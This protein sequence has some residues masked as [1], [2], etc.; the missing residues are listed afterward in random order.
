MINQNT[1]LILGAGSSHEAGFPLGEKLIKEIY[2]F[3]QEQTTGY[4]RHSD[5]HIAPHLLQNVYLLQLL[6]DQAGEK[7]QDGNTYSVDDIKAF[8]RDLWDSKVASIDDFLFHRKEY[9]LIGK[10]CILFVLSKYEDPNRFFPKKVSP[11]QW[12]YP[13]WGWYSYLWRQLQES[14]DGDFDI[15]KKNRLCVLTFNYDRSLEYF[16]FNA[17][18][19]T[20]GLHAKECDIASFFESIQIFHVYGELG[21]LPWKFNCL[22]E[23]REKHKNQPEVINDFSP[24]QL[25][26]IFRLHGNSGEFGMSQ[27]DFGV[28]GPILNEE[29]RKK[30]AQGLIDK[31]KA[32]KIY[33]EVPPNEDR[34]RN[35]LSTAQ[36]IYFLGCGYHQQNLEVIRL[37]TI[38][39]PL[40]APIFGSAVGFSQQEK[41]QKETNLKLFTRDIVQLFHHWDGYPSGD[42]R[43]ESYLRNV[44][45][46]LI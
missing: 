29:T 27:G 36:R 43:I 4:C 2:S 34:Y 40:E 9:A 18:K 26:I 21:I 44:A 16:L 22:N 6:L 12:G 45:P 39:Q 3:V 17:I 37:N 23:Y 14:T 24:I 30:F 10:L 19:A 35:I 7:R 20:Y 5:G 31:A 41:N 42:Q 46:L 1:V 11:D 25:G 15:L 32:I 13:G 28:A 8:A 33:H 38:F